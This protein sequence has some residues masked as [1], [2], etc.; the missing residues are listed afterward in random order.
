M[1]GS[2]GEEHDELCDSYLARRLGHAIVVD[3]QLGCW[4][5]HMYQRAVDLAYNFRI[6]YHLMYSLR[7]LR[8]GSQAVNAAPCFSRGNSGEQQCL[9]WKYAKIDESQQLAG[10]DN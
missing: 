7:D 9:D 1:L 5:E 6:I 3:N 10:G 2:V 4:R 8:V